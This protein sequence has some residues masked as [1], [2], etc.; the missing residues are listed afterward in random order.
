MERVQI[1]DIA[2]IGPRCGSHVRNSGMT[3]TSSDRYKT[4]CSHYSTSR[5]IKS[6]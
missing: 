4:P 3:D 2:E 5:L 1:C 6:L